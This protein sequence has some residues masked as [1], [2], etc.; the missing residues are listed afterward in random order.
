MLAFVI[1]IYSTCLVC[2]HEQLHY[3]HMDNSNCHA[4]A[5]GLWSIKKILSDTAIY[6]QKCVFFMFWLFQQQLLRLFIIQS[7]WSIPSPMTI[8]N[9]A[10]FLS[11]PYWSVP[12]IPYW[13][14]FGESLEENTC[15]DIVQ[16]SANQSVTFHVICSGIP[17]KHDKAKY[18][19]ISGLKRT[20]PRRIRTR[21][22]S[23]RG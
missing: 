2:V 15:I 5:Q 21:K 3:I 18:P 19:I 10:Y 4:R 8:C 23:S 22:P 13:S 6:W 20:K 16:L 1:S 9:H 7:H 11:K 17:T 12:I 14:S